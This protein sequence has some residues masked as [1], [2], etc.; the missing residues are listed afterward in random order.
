MRLPF[1]GWEPLC[2][3]IKKGDSW[4]DLPVIVVVMAKYNCK[5]AIFQWEGLMLLCHASQSLEDLAT[6]GDLLI[7]GI[8]LYTWW[9][10]QY[11]KNEKR[12]FAA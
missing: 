10:S 5:F 6:V 2:P 8:R 11:G 12:C 4:E 7:L 1:P 3:A 9:P